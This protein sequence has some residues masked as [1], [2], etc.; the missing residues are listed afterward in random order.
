M[1][2]PSR[3][4]PKRRLGECVDVVV[5]FLESAIGGVQWRERAGG[6]RLGPVGRRV[7]LEY[8]VGAADLNLVVDDNGPLRAG[9]GRAHLNKLAN[10][11]EELSEGD[12]LVDV[13]FRA[14]P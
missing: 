12:W 10:V 5:D 1:R 4:S 8:V 9:H 3:Q 13:V 6:G 2:T 14:R 11:L 7:I